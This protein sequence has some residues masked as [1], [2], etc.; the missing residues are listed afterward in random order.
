MG[1]V[2][3][4]ENMFGVFCYWCLGKLVG[5]NEFIYIDRLEIVDNFKEVNVI[6]NSKN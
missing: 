5:K 6:D 2:C 1:G 4:L 3:F